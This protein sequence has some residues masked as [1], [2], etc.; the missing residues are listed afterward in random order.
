YQSLLTMY[1]EY[2]TTLQVLNSEG[3][4]LKAYQLGDISFSEYYVELEFYYSA[5][6]ALL[7]MEKQLHL[8]KVQLLAHQL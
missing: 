3:L 4:L 6:D 1:N 8:I 7:D 2:N 5:L